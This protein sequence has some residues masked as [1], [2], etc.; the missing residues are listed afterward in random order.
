VSRAIAREH[1]TRRLVVA[2]CVALLFARPLHAQAEFAQTLNWGSGL[3]DIPTAWVAPLTGDFSLNWSAKSLQTSPAIPQ[4]DN[5]L[6]AKGALQLALFGRAEI[7][8]SVLSSDF[9]HGFYGQALILNQE[10]FRGHAGAFLPSVAFGVRNVGPYDHIDRFGLGYEETLPASGGSAPVIVADSL[11]RAFKT[12]NTLYGVATKSFSLTDL[13]SVWPDIGISL[14]VGYGNGLFSNHGSIPVRDYAADATGGLFYGIKTDFRPSTNTMISLMAENNAWDFNVGTA[15][16]YR[17]LRA[18]VDVTELAAGSPHLTAGD[19]ATA[20]YR[21]PKINFTLG[22]ASNIF[23]LVRGNVLENR[24]AQLRKQRDVL[25]A[26]IAQRQ[27]HIAQLQGE[28]RHYEAQ[29]LLE[30][31]ERRAQAQT[32]LQTETEALHRLEER[33]KRIE[34]ETQGEPEPTPPPA[35]PAATQPAPPPANP[36]ANP[37]AGSPAPGSPPPSTGHT[38]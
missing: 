15:V 18:G 38:L 32:E 36:P 2:A 31:E 17:G 33:L 7:G 21:Y 19:P 28:I 23:A 22:W 30:L 25:L 13:R 37:P 10:D 16:S 6:T 26:D 34:A 4:Y 8:M 24:A 27:T 5:S 1:G 12:G 3:I 9:E 11:H 14:T 20:L 29:N 35:P